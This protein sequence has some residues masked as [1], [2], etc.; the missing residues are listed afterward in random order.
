VFRTAPKVEIHQSGRLLWSGRIPRLA[1][2]RSAS[3]PA[4]WLQAVDMTGAP[5]EVRVP[6]G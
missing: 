3:L 2:G 1:P 6:R 4:R 5:I